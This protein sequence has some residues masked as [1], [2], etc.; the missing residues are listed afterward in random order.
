MTGSRLPHALYAAFAC[1]CASALVWPIYGWVGAA[2]E[3]RLLGLPPAFAWNVGWVL[4]A[5]LA[6]L[7]YD[8]GKSAGKALAL[9]AAFLALAALLLFLAGGALRDSLFGLIGGGEDTL[10]AKPGHR[11]WIIGVSATYLVLCL[12]VGLWPGRKTSASAVGY[13][14]GDRALGTVVMYF[15]TGATIFSSIAFLGMPGW[16]YSKGVAALYV[17]GYGALGFV[18]FY[19]LGPRAARV[20]REYG[21][22]TQAEMVA[23]RFDS[24]VL[25]GLMALVTIYAL[26]PYVAIQMKGAGLVLEAITGGDVPEHWGAFIVYAVV[27]TYVLRSGVLGVGWTN[28]FQGIL[29]MVLAWIFGLYLPWRLYGGVGPMF[30]RIA[31]ERPELLSAPGLAAPSVDA[32]GVIVRSG[33]WSWGTYTT[34]VLVSIIGFSCWPQLF[35]RAFSARSERVLKRT[36]V[37]YPTFQIF[38]VPIL[39]IGFAGVL[40]ATPPTSSDQVLPHMLVQLDLPAVFV[41][42]FCAGALAASMS[43][44]DALLHTAASVGVRDGFVTTFG[45]QLAPETERR[46]IRIGVVVVAVGAYALAMGYRGSIAGLL[47]Y[48]YGPIAQFAPV[49]VATLYWR[50]ATEAGVVAGLVAGIGVSILCQAV[51]SPYGWHVGAWGLI[52]NVA[53]L[54][55][56]SLATGRGGRQGGN[57]LDVAGR[58]PTA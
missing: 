12:G 32:D 6:L 58:A 33:P 57:F 49:V 34:S 47:L 9:V 43:S 23:K 14:A 8:R 44:G 55:L 45:K 29:M 53:T 36:V 51:G 46:W 24:R 28:T 10:G 2:S 25:A 4:A 42:L 30:E 15:I 35:M 56:V 54:V 39:L 20:G 1:L 38:L 31:A 13:V 50:R 5:F 22:I 3:P 40:F 26:V 21:L 17:L 7:T 27:V 18:P 48:A 52:A 37:L 16:A 11:A 19:F 41:G